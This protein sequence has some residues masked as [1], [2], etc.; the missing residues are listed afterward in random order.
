MSLL[1]RFT[2]AKTPGDL[3]QPV[4]QAYPSLFDLKAHAA[5]LAGKGGVYALWHLGV[6]P[7]WLHIGAGPSLG[8]CMTGAATALAVSPW[9][10][11][12]GLYAAWVFMDSTRWPGIVQGLRFRLAPALQD[13]AFPEDAVWD[14]ATAPVVFL[15]PPGTTEQ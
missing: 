7:Q 1:A 14:P 8:A 6:R 5:A 13:V 15:L 9:R 11:N 10:G 3:W 2:K 12:G 4:D